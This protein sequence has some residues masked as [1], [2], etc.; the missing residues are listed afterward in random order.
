MP[1]IQMG[2]L[3]R[4]LLYLIEIRHRGFW[5]KW[6]RWA[7]VGMN[8]DMCLNCKSFVDISVSLAMFCC[9]WFELIDNVDRRVELRGRS[10]EVIEWQHGSCLRLNFFPSRSITSHKANPH[11]SST[12]FW[13]AQQSRKSFDRELPKKSQAI[14]RN[15]FR[16][17]T[18]VSRLGRLEIVRRYYWNCHIRKSGC[19]LTTHN[20]PVSLS[21]G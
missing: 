7:F 8:D 15:M 2:L 13:I 9:N 16:N 4:F 20:P 11:S 18:K 19:Q 10:S 12:P 14:R 17:A 1:S 21:R 5:S 3:P 6:A